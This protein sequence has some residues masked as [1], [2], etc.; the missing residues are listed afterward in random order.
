MV[1]LTKSAQ[2]RHLPSRL[3]VMAIIAIILRRFAESGLEAALKEG[4]HPPYK[5]VTVTCS[6]GESFVTKSTKPELRVEICSNCHPF[7]SGQ[8]KFVDSGGRVERFRKKYG[9]P[10]NQESV[11]TAPPGSESET[12][13]SETGESEV[14]KPGD[15]EAGYEIGSGEQS[16][17]K[18]AEAPGE[19][20]SPATG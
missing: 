16:D 11:D 7:Y 17:E 19:E 5:E 4:I 6:C 10:D 8:Q 12:G 20:E 2:G 13:A 14:D 3:L 1:P 15:K 9:L 18:D